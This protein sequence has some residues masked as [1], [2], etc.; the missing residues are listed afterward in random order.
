VELPAVTAH[1]AAEDLQ[2]SVPVGVVEDDR[3]TVVAA[4][5]EVVVRACGK[6]STLATHHIRR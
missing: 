2:E 1:D 3:S 4:R 6:V 5:T